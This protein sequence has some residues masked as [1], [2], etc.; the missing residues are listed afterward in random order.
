ML[1][2]LLQSVLV[3]WHDEGAECRENLDRVD[4]VLLNMAIEDELIV[5]MDAIF[6]TQRNLVP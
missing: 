5:W 1:L 6:K 2:F 4:G 3:D